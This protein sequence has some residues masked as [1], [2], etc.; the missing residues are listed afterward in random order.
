MT[1]EEYETFLVE[2]TNKIIEDLVRIVTKIIINLY[3]VEND[4]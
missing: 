1:R 2:E 4:D 3:E